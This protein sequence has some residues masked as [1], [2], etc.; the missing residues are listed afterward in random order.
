VGPVSDVTHSLAIHYGTRSFEVSER[1][2]EDKPEIH[3][4]ERDVTP[5]NELALCLGVVNTI[6]KT[7]ARNFLID[8]MIIVH[9]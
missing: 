9:V 8:R 7:Q 2:R 6:M 5:W 1:R 3:S 4:E